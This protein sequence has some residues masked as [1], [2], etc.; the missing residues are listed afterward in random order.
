MNISCF[1]TYSEVGGVRNFLII[2][3]L[4]YLQPIAES[5]VIMGGVYAGT[6]TSTK[7]GRGYAD[8]DAGA[9]AVGETTYAN[10]QTETTVRKTD[11]LDYSRA[12]ARSEAYARTGNQTASS[13]SSSSSTSFYLNN[14]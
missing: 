3:D 1:K 11:S 9:V 14:R 12:N 8:A 7:T 5:S 2:S 10:A 13:R 6:V 4:S